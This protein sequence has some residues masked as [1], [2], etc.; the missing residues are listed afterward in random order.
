MSDATS[1]AS[2]LPT[3]AAPVEPP[4]TVHQLGT[5]LLK[6]YGLHEGKFEIMLEYQVGNALLGTA[7]GPATPGLVIGVSRIGLLPTSADG[8]NTLDASLLNPAAP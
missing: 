1:P 8:P 5:L 3:V 4:L 6:Q 7:A 2:V